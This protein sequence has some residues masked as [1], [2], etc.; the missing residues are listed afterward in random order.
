MRLT[1]RLMPSLKLLTAVSVVWLALVGSGIVPSAP[2]ARGATEAAG[3]APSTAA[4]P[5][6]G[7]GGYRE[8]GRW[9]T[10]ERPRAVAVDNQ[11]RVL[12]AVGEKVITYNR[13]GRRLRSFAT[14]TTKGYGLTVGPNGNIYLSEYGGNPSAVHVYKPSGKLVGSL[15]ETDGSSFA[16]WG[17][18]TLPS[19]QLWIANA[20]GNTVD[21]ALPSATSVGG[22]G[23][24]N[25]RFDVPV[26]V[27]YSAKRVFVVDSDNSRIQRFTPAGKFERKW[28][29]YGTGPGQLRSPLS[30]DTGK[31]GVVLVLDSASVDDSQ[32]E[33]YRPTGKHLRA[34]KIR[35]SKTFGLAADAKGNVYVTGLLS[36]PNGGWGVVRL[37]PRW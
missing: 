6:A 11:G 33:A 36:Y 21:R 29:Q 4:L 3:P 10:E 23:T 27:A 28:G 9:L 22:P 7:V 24:G 13:N 35:A 18:E 20:T 15:V 17:V 37:S 30:I 14:G 26:D 1:G 5:K 31:Q 19:G 34:S 32:L 16:P 12:V 25:G 2:T 8:T